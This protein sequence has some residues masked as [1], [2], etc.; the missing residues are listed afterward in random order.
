MGDFEQAQSCWRE[1][2]RHDPRHANAR[3]ELASMLRGKLP[4]HDL[5]AMRQLVTEPHVCEEERSNL[6]FGL[7]RCST[8]EA[9]MPLR[10]SS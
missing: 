5:T 7:R 8:D 6:Y 3:A 10:R 4:D 1:A 2:L 9:S